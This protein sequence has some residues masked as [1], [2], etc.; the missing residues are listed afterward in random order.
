MSAPEPVEYQAKAIEKIA[1]ALVALASADQS[2]DRLVVLK[3]PTGSGKTLMVASALADAYDNPA[4]RPF[5]VLWLTPG[6]GDLHKQSAKALEYLL[7][8]RSLQVLLLDDQDDIVKH[9]NPAPGSV[10]VVNWEKLRMEK[11]GKWAN[12]ML[13]E[14][15]N[16]TLFTLLAAAS[17][18]GLDLIAVIDESHLSL[19]A[20]RSSKLMAAINEKRPFIQLELSATPTTQLDQD[21]VADGVQHYVR[22]KFEDV[23]AEGMVRKS[24]LL[25]ED[26]AGVMGAHAKDSLQ[27]QVLWAA[28]EKTEAL[29]AAYVAAGSPVRPLLL[30]QYPDGAKAEQLADIVEDFLA[31]RGLV[32][33][34]TF[35]TWL[36]GDHSDDLEKIALNTSPYRALIFKQA[37]ATGWDCPRAQVLVQFRD[38]RSPIFQ[39]QTLG[40]ILRSPEQ[41]H[42]DDESLNV[43]YVFS[44]L[45]GARVRIETD[46]PDAKVRDMT[47]RRSSD[48]PPQG[49]ML[50]STFQ[51]RTREFHYPMTSNLTMPLNATLDAKV[52][53]LLTAVPYTA[54][55]VSVL[56]DAIVTTQ[57]LAAESS[58]EMKGGTATG[59]LDDVIV[60]ALYNQLLVQRIGAYR[61]RAQSLSRIKNVIA[62]WFKT[63]RP[64]WT[65][66]EIQHFALRHQEEFMA[67][68]DEA[69]HA[70]R[71]AEE[72]VAI[73][74]ARG[75]R[76][77]T[78]EWEVP[79]AELVASKDC[80]AAGD[81]FLFVPPLVPIS[82]S[83]PEKR[84]EA[85][86]VKQYASRVVQWWWRN[87]EQDERFL[88]VVYD[89]P[90]LSG[91]GAA[92]GKSAAAPTTEEHITYPDYLVSCADGAVWAIEVKDVDDKDGAVGGVTHAK[93]RGLAK[94]AL[95]MKSLR[96]SQENLIG[97]ATIRAGVVV[98]TEL[99]PGVI[100]VSLG[101]PDA[102]QPPTAPNLASEAGWTSLNL[103]SGDPRGSA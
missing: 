35:A 60:Q 57:Q 13:A 43:A 91:T 93:A 11:D 45:E 55:Q 27:V 69:C 92:T 89:R 68:V 26:L 81:G 34:K 78:T 32:K 76:R 25:N 28:W 44:D 66:D 102:W 30:I 39:I 4:G 48:Y 101:D 10:F 22:V 70:A 79:V 95:A 46:E 52:A 14:G 72:A 49:L 85:Y 54:T 88:G 100:T 47:I 64:D 98:P 2:K 36:S 37:I 21:L 19:R 38:P 73:A 84:F 7:T 5:I 75:K 77:T 15:E 31:A 99:A 74:R 65:A 87:G 3:A 41:T 103:S 17:S 12:K 67:S 56:S 6:K 9:Q 40:R 86:L 63:K 16:A 24:V 8:G 90:V 1:G 82:R 53:P 20:P 50:H 23:E 83:T 96:P 97:L 29:T 80:E 59:D 42:Y 62:T 71:A 51:P 18:R 33:D 58:H 61:S 94:W